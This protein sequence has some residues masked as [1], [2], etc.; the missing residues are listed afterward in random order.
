MKKCFLSIET[1]LNRIFL[2]LYYKQKLYSLKKNLEHSIE[3]EINKMLGNILNEAKAKFSELD[4]ILVSLGPGSYTGTRVGLAA[5]KAISVSIDK[6]LLGYTNFD[7]IYKQGLLEKYIKK[8]SLSGI[9]IRANKNE[10]YY[11]KINKETFSRIKVV[12]INE[13]KDNLSSSFKLIG[14]C[15]SFYNFQGYKSCLPKKH[16]I[17]EV[18]KSNYKSMDKINENE[19][20]PLYIRGHYA[21]KNNEK[22]K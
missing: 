4:S 15:S 12:N 11:Q 3:V 9:I 19:L 8:N 2:V 1:S 18:Y 6:P 10:C 21:E 17:L 13:I 14:N 16:A 5:A 7:A 20:V 22:R